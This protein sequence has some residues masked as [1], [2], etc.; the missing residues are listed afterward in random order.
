MVEFMLRSAL[1]FELVNPGLVTTCFV[2]TTID[3]QTEQMAGTFSYSKAVV[4]GVPESLPAAALRTC[5]SGEP[6]DLQR[7]REQHDQYVKVVPS[8]YQACWQRL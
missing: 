4:C 7:A 2:T 6:V 1:T 8:E 3:T 5:D